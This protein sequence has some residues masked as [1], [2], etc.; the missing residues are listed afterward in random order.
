MKT[1][2]SNKYKNNK[3]KNKLACLINKIKALIIIIQISQECQINLLTTKAVVI[4]THS[5]QDQLSPLI[6]RLKTD[7]MLKLKIKNIIL[8]F[9]VPHYKQ[10]HKVLRCLLTLSVTN[11]Y[12]IM[13]SLHKLLLLIPLI[14]AKR[15]SQLFKNDR[16]QYQI[17]KAQP[18]ILMRAVNK[19]KIENYLIQKT[20]RYL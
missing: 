13:G 4:I 14:R 6:N 12:K 9:K 17:K 5:T 3:F 1:C 8:T 16:N 15:K 10:I 19:F 7:T 20:M 11:H 18:K 2:H